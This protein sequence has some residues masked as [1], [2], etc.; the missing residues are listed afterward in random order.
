MESII[1]AHISYQL[2]FRSELLPLANDSPLLVSD[3][4]NSLS[5]FKL[6]PFQEVQSE[7]VIATKDLISL[8]VE[9]DEG[10]CGY[11]HVHHLEQGVQE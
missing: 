2:M 4:L 8:N 7:F 11:F 10:I 3:I 1:N 9:T 6:V 5:V